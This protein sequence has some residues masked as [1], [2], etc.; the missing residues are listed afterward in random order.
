M[1]NK[2]FVLVY[3]EVDNTF[4]VLDDSQEKLVGLDSVMVK[5]DK[6]WFQGL[7]KYR[8]S[9]AKCE[10]K[11][12]KIK[13]GKLVVSDNEFEG[14][15]K[16]LTS[17]K[18]KYYCALC[19]FIVVI[20]LFVE[21]TSNYEQNLVRVDHYLRERVENQ[22]IETCEQIAL[23]QTTE[24]ITVIERG[25]ENP[26]RDNVELGIEM[27][28]IKTDISELKDLNLKILKILKKSKQDSDWPTEI[29]I[30]FAQILLFLSIFCIQK[31]LFN[32]LRC[33]MEKI[34][35]I[36]Q[37]LLGTSISPV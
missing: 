19:V 1:E 4:C 21:P 6:K 37:L 16:S 8:G 18:S 29:V 30:F 35:S 27:R 33:S 10:A 5:F 28:Q 36:F 3:F 7:V 32:F 12:E 2:N 24:Q 15:N 34:F 23:E 14:I 26:S 9:K 22:E 31:F 13:D 17:K 20:F 25:L 11:G